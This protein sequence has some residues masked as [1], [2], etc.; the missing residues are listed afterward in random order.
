MKWIGSPVSETWPFEIRH[1]TRGAFWTPILRKGSRD[2]RG[3][4]SNVERAMG[5]F[6]IRS[7][8][9]HCAI[10]NHSNSAAICHRISATLGSIQRGGGSKF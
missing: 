8:C 2:R 3:Q 9:D 4:R 5:W 6:P 1:I 7:N 10:S